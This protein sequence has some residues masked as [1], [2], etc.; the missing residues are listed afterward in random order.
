MRKTTFIKTTL[1]AIG[2]L[3]ASTSAWAQTNSYLG[4]D[5][6]FE[7]TATIDNTATGALLPVAS[8]WSKANTNITIANET[9]T[10]RS[11]S[12]S[13]K[14]TSSSATT[15]RIW[16]PLVT[17]SASTTKWV[18]QYYR[19]AT[20]L[21]ATIQ[22][23][24]YNY[25]QTTE[26]GSGSYTTVSAINTW[27]KVTYAPTSVV[28]A[29]QGA[30]GILAKMKTTTGDMFFDDFCMYESS[31]GVDTSAPN[32]PTAPVVGNATTTSLDVSWTAA[33]GGVDGGGYLV[34]RGIAD[35]TT[36]P[37]ANGIYAVGNT[38]AA[39]MTVVYQGTGTSFTDN[40]LASNTTYYY[41]IYTY[42]K[43][44]NYSGALTTNGATSVAGGL[45]SP[46]LTADASSNTVDNDIDISFTPDATWEGLITAVKIG[47]TALTVTTDY[48]VSSGIIKLKPSGG[49]SLLRIP[50]SKAV[51]VEATG[52]LTASATQDILVG[53]PVS[54]NSTVVP[55]GALAANTSRTFTCTAKDQYSNLVSGYTF[56]YNATITNN[57]ATTAETYTIDGVA[58]TSTAT[59]VSLTTVTNG[60][61]VTTFTVALPAVID[62]N[63]G[64][65]VQVKLSD[66]TT[67]V[68]TPSSFTQLLSQT[69]TFGALSNVT[70][71][72][73]NFDLTATASSGLAV[74]YASS[75]TTVA[76][77]SGSTVTI[78]GPGS[79]NITASQAGNGSYNAASNVIQALTV[80]VKP[81]TVTTP[82]VTTKTYN[83]TN[84]AVI[85][86]TLSGIVGLDVVTL[87]GTGTFA[88]VNVGTGIAVTS[89]STLG[90]ANAS[91]YSITQPIGLTGE[92]IKADQTITFN[93]AIPAK[94]TTDAPF[95]VTATATSGLTVSFESSNTNVATVSGNTVTI[96]GVGTATIS[97]SQAG[98]GNYNAAPAGQN[99]ALTVNF[100]APVATEP[101][102]RTGNSFF[103]NWE[104]VAGATG[105]ILDVYTKSG[106][107]VSDLIISEYL[108]G[109]S[110]NKA[111]EIYNGTGVSVDL[112]GYSLKKQVNGAGAYGNELVLSGSLANK[113][114]YVIAN[115]SANASIT[116]L[117]NLTTSL[118]VMTFNG[119]DAIGLFKAGTQID[120]VG[121]FNQVANWGIDVTLS[122]KTSVTAPKATYDA[123]DW[124][125][126][127]TDYYSGLGLFQV[128]T[129]V[130]G[131]PFS[132]SGGA[133]VSK[134]ITGLAWDTYYYTVDATDG[135]FTSADSNEKS[136]LIDLATNINNPSN[137][138]IYVANGQLI[139]TGAS[140][141]SVYNT[142]GL[143]VA[144]VNAANTKSP[145]ALR[146]G[147]YFVK[148]AT[149]TQK[150]M[151][152]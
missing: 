126:L 26:A 84:A 104:A 119:N 97:A 71:G 69:I 118:A 98:D 66:G 22:N 125:I 45:A 13:L 121:V 38:I 32:D 18:V 61:G 113:G 68:G 137:S 59:G 57:D 96:V 49:N 51:T 55:S 106:P 91:K 110:N 47:G 144:K 37:N 20:S 25:R 138:K 152:K 7:G 31:T 29:T 120:E 86:G 115:S 60:S 77:V 132:V 58:K 35:P 127:A 100:V 33:S 88:D 23:Q 48:V 123:A 16:S 111:L 10:V 109:T 122:R 64:I 44:Y 76:T 129:P 1:L 147:V 105:Y 19:R 42:D 11:G 17:M 102:V 34:V 89:T 134:Q 141:Y 43:A 21:T 67:S 114:T 143:E 81:L 112:S 14:V 70:Y 83:G 46:T 101:T 85:T 9:S 73:S 103:A 75:N 40:S 52:Y 117:A 93:T 116:G 65:S 36:A 94:V 131:S 56:K 107:S 124:D 28:S 72:G 53:F 4:L 145:L 12:N 82:A 6:G 90:G 130:A 54:A 146:S 78:V 133:T 87:T 62:G 95:A 8:K 15:S 27:E 139:V 108:E 39:G 140:E 24:S 92:I 74:S 30:A 2:L 63:D 148:T 99:Q 50:G 80:D 151:V 149:A 128:N 136:A 79:T 135:V 5:G 150:I 41:R 142:Q 3:L